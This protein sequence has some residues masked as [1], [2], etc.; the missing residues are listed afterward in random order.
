ML[1]LGP[2]RSLPSLASAAPRWFRRGPPKKTSPTSNIGRSLAV[3]W[4]AMGIDGSEG[5]A[6]SEGSDGADVIDYSHSVAVSAHMAPILIFTVLS[7]VFCAI[8]RRATSGR[9]LFSRITQGAIWQ[10][11][12]HLAILGKIWQDLT[13]FGKIW[14]VT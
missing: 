13:R 5:S 11:W 12:K 8:V 2:S 9:L 4:E 10:D 14:R 1:Q 6:G 3:G 7:V